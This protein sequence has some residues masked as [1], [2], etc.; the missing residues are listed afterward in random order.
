MSA[1]GS[2]LHHPGVDDEDEEFDD[3]KDAKS[4]IG[5]GIESERYSINSAARGIVG[6]QPVDTQQRLLG[7]YRATGGIKSLKSNSSGKYGRSEK[8]LSFKTCNGG[9]DEDFPEAN[10]D[11]FPHEVI[12]EQ[13]GQDS[14]HVQSSEEVGR[15]PSIIGKLKPIG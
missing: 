15:A 8:E 13:I 6:K 5:A 2:L 4:T 1:K 3:F 14:T 11:E 7:K 12:D 9:D 10:D